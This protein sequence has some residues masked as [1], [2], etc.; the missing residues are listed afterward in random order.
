MIKK[1]A[2]IYEICLVSKLCENLL[3]KIRSQLLIAN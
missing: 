1:V 3:T 2:K